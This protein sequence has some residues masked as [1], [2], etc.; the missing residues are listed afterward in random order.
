MVWRPGRGLNGAVADGV[1]ALAAIGFDRV[2]VAHADLPLA[3]DLAWPARHDGVTLVPDRR[4]D[5]TNVACVP[6]GAR[7]SSS[8]TARARSGATA[9][10]RA[11]SASSLRVVREPTLGWD[12]DLPADLDHPAVSALR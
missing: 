11:G 10:R 2:V 7:A 6:T 1:A 9:P 8:A 5:G 12:V 3:V 4:D